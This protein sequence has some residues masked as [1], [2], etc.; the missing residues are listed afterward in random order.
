MPRYVSAGV[1][2]LFEKH[3]VLH[4]TIKNTMEEEQLEKVCYVC[5]N[6]YSFLIAL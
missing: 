5:L 1:K 6:I 4:F 3:I 2:H